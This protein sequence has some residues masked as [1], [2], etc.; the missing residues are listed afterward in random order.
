[1]TKIKKIW[2][3]TSNGKKSQC[4]AIYDTD[5]IF[6][7]INAGTHGYSMGQIY[8]NRQGCFHFDEIEIKVPSYTVHK[9]EKKDN[10]R[11]FIKCRGTL[12]ITGS[13]A[14]IV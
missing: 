7:T 13:K 6:P 10:P 3:K 9:P 11:F 14:E 4:A 2:D 12:K 8:E 1:M 5:G